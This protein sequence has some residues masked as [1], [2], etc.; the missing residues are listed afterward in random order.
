MNMTHESVAWG[1]HLLN[2]G[3]IRGAVCNVDASVAAAVWSHAS[4]RACAC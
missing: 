3:H 1:L 2:V 4:V